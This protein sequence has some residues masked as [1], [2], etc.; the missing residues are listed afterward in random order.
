MYAAG[1]GAQIMGAAGAQPDRR[2][3]DLTDCG[4]LPLRHPRRAR[5]R[6]A[7]R[8]RCLLVLVFLLLVLVL[9]FL[10]VLVLLVLF[11][12]I[13]VLLLLLDVLLLLLASYHAVRP[14]DA[15]CGRR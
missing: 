2:P 11:V 13:L 6:H 5:R 1:D 8:R 9:L 15:A 3:Q 14:G 7:A 10:L 4:I 12:L